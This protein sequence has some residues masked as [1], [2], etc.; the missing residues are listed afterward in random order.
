MIRKLFLVLAIV[1]FAVRPNPAHS[2]SG[3]HGGHGHHHGN[4]RFHHFSSFIFVY[5][6]F[7]SSASWG[8]AG[9]EPGPA[10]PRQI[11]RAR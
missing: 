4:H 8:H 2:W 7:S 1:V 5:D 3:G 11:P 9:R 10:C 6:P